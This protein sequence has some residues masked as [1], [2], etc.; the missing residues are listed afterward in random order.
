MSKGL[1]NDANSS[2]AGWTTD[3]TGR[4]TTG[5]LYLACTAVAIGVGAF[6]F[7]RTALLILVLPRPPPPIIALSV[8]S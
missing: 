5:S 3:F 8:R 1:A 7:A 6:F 4:L 2:G